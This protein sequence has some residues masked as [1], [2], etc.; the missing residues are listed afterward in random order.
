M[1]TERVTLGRIML[2][3]D[4]APLQAQLLRILEKATVRVSPDHVVSL[5]L[6]AELASRVAPQLTFVLFASCD[7]RVLQCL[8]ELRAVSPA[9][10][11]AVGPAHS[12]SFILDALRAGADEYL[13]LAALDQEVMNSLAKFRQK[14]GKAASAAS[15]G[16]VVG[17]IGASGGTGSSFVAANVATALAQ[18][19]GDCG[20]IDLRLSAGDLSA[21][22]N[23]RPQHT[24]ADICENI[25]RADLAMF[26]SVLAFHSSGVGLIAAPLDM[27]R[28]ACV[29][30]R[31]VRQVLALAR[32]RFRFV[33]VDVENRPG[34]TFSQTVSLSDQLL[35]VTRL[36][37]TSVRNTQKLLFHLD[38]LGIEP[39][40]VFLVANRYRQAREIPVK[41]VQAAIGRKIDAYIREDPSR[42]NRCVNGG[43]LLLTEFPHSAVAKQIRIVAQ[44]VNGSCNGHTK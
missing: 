4:E 19:H 36:D 44:A 42:V 25:E 23:L 8:R 32:S 13:D 20:L 9:R 21:L 7:A 26:D 28:G 41:K 30:D 31:G 16:R 1:E 6:A 37:Y 34:E 29:T 43:K 18:L 39:E 10:L 11:C 24:L 5:R 22:F 27:N 3:G 35:L 14:V 40:R 38:G 2:V 17:V 15:P 33:V 12:A